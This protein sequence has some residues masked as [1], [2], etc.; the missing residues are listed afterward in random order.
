MAS[1]FHGERGRSAALYIAVTA[2][3]A[4]VVTAAFL[5]APQ[6]ER[7][8]E[9]YARIAMGTLVEVALYDGDRS[10]FDEA[11]E[12]AFAEIERLEALLSAYRPDSDVARLGAGRGPVRVSA[13]T[14]E[15]VET[16]LRIARLSGGAFD[17][18]VGVLG[19]LWSFDGSERPVPSD[20]EIER[21]L[22]L[23]DYRGI[24][25][26]AR[27]STVELRRGG[28]AVVLGGVAKGFIVGRAVDA[29]K[30]HGV[31]AGIVTAGGDMTVFGGSGRP[32]TIGIR[33]PR[34]PGRLLGELRIA[35]GAVA[36][37]GDYERFFMKDGVRYHHIIDPST[38]RPARASQSA[39]VVAAD[40]A[41]ADALSTAM[42]VMGA[43]RA[44]TLADSLDGVECL[45]VDAQ[46]GIHMSKGMEEMAVLAARK[47]P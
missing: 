5:R 13:E 43:D 30:S 24:V 17:P 27:E 1:I 10:R 29:L 11:A 21:L 8:V 40:P 44:V 34:A 7:S 42:F 6:P 37:S 9:T 46:G 2:F 14:V 26:D 32:F 35:D 12:A 16:A 4:L 38:G 39:T 47:T 25:V 18:T 3:V 41:L 31:T 33:H 22:P 15:V 23:V 19:A 28:M 36:T 20:G 45:V